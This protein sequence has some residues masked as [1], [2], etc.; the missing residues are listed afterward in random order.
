VFLHFRDWASGSSNLAENERII[1]TMIVL[2][3]IGTHNADGTEGG[4]SL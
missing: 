1:L 3:V 2:L 4:Y